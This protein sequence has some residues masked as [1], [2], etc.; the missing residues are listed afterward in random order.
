MRRG[1]EATLGDRDH[2]VADPQADRDFLGPAGD[3]DRNWPPGAFRTS[4]S[5]QAT[6]RLRPAP[7]ALRIA[8]LAAHRP[9]KCSIACF[10]DWQKRISRSV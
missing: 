1:I 9:A 5:V 2:E 4:I 10:R 7:R 3:E 8:S 6:P